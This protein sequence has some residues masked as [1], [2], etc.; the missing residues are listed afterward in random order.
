[1]QEITAQQ[2]VRRGNR[3]GA[4]FSGRLLERRLCLLRP[5]HPKIAE[6]EGR[7]QVDHALIGSPIAY[8][9]LD[10]HI[11]R[12]DLCVLHEYVEIAVFVEYAGIDQFVFGV[13]PAAVSILV[14]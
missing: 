6:P 3:A 10:Q 1:M 7:Q 4:A 13:H 2:C 12:R 9:D 8:A 11:G 14:N 5:P